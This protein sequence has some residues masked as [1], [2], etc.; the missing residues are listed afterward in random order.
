VAT[1]LSQSTSM[2]GSSASVSVVDFFL[3]TFAPQ[4]LSI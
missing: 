4:L 1:P 2:M 3:A